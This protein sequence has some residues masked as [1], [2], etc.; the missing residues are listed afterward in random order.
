M[1]VAKPLPAACSRSCAEPGGTIG[2]YP[3]VFS[4]FVNADQRMT[5][6]FFGGVVFPGP[7]KLALITACLMCYGKTVICL[8]FA[9]GLSAKS[10]GLEKFALCKINFALTTQTLNNRYE[11]F[12]KQ[13][14]KSPRV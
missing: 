4:Y 10:A 8:G 13:I 3:Q 5:P 7:E 14:S 2:V 1:A 6:E 11:R 12:I 9:A